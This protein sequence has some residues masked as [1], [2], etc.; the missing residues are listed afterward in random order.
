[1]EY[2]RKYLKRLEIVNGIG[3]FTND[4]V[5]SSLYIR[6]TLT[7]I[8]QW[9]T[10]DT[11]FRKYMYVK[12]FQFFILTHIFLDSSQ[13]MFQRHNIKQSCFAISLYIYIIEI[14]LNLLTSAS[15]MYFGQF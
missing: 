4:G 13:V 5:T 15:E 12:S 9:G 2:E 11:L 7:G 3:I 8:N 10:H 1:M 6:V 14:N